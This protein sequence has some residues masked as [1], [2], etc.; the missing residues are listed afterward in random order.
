M[1]NYIRTMTE[2]VA[3]Q[4]AFMTNMTEMLTKLS[5]HMTG[6]KEKDKYAYDPEENNFLKDGFNIKKFFKNIA[7]DPLYGQSAISGINVLSQAIF[8][9]SPKFFK[10]DLNAINLNDLMSNIN[11]IQ[12][13]ISA[14]FPSLKKFKK[15]DKSIN[16]F[17]KIFFAKAKEGKLGGIF[18]GDFLK[19]VMLVLSC[20]V[21]RK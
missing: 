20:V 9:K 8:G 17:S 1:N 7:E 19:E 3:K 18:Q 5:N 16:N 15:V 11:P 2:H 14:L 21:A 4:Q 10:D 6:T 13:A 12:L